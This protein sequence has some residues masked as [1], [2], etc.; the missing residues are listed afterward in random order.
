[1]FVSLLSMLGESSTVYMDLHTSLNYAEHAGRL[2]DKF[3]AS[4]VLKYCST[5]LHFFKLLSSLG[6]LMETITVVQMAD[7]LLTSSLS[8]SR[9]QGASGGR[10]TI[11]ALRWLS[12]IAMVDALQT[13]MYHQVINAFVVAKHTRDQQETAPFSLWGGNVV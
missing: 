12:K 3:A 4:T 8:K 1:M 5:A 7:I 9:D 13:L 6:Y 11:K 2:L 10:A